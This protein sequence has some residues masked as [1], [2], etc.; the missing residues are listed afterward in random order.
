MAAIAMD[1]SGSS[2]AARAGGKPRASAMASSDRKAAMR[3]DAGALEFEASPIRRS[4]ARR[5]ITVNLATAASRLMA[6]S[7]ERSAM[8]ASISL[9]DEALMTKEVDGEDGRKAVLS[10]QTE[11]YCTLTTSAARR[12]SRRVSSRELSNFGR[13]SP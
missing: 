7:E 12:L 8:R 10:Q 3:A 4:T 1:E 6:L 2:N 11:S 5:P 13:S 9:P